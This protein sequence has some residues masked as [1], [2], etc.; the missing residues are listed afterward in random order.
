MIIDFH[1]HI[2]PGMDD[3]SP[4]V[5]TSI[6]MLNRSSGQGTALQI[7]TPHFYSWKEDIPSF[8]ERRERSVRRLLMRYWRP[9]P[10]LAVGSETAFFKD[11]SRIDLSPLCIGKTKTLLLEM[12]FESWDTGTVE[13]LEALSLDGGYRL[14]LAHIE[15]YLKYPGNTE[16]LMLLRRIPVYMQGNAE[17]F[18]SLKER[19]RM[20]DLVSSGTISVL[21][22]DAHN[23]EDRRPMLGPARRVIERKLGT[24]ELERIDCT[25]ERLLRRN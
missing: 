3:G 17:S 12:P 11:I 15:R 18:L 24:R 20:L 13:E 8:L 5:E 10:R 14:V 21:G 22:S 16:K 9:E 19:H 25:A 1:S 4:D 6:R 23:M 7:L 2:L